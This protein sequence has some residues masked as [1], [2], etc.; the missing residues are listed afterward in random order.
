M[1][2]LTDQRHGPVQRPPPEVIEPGTADQGDGAVMT[3]VEHL[4]ELR[5]RI[6]I[7]ILAI[8]L[9][10][11]VGFILTPDAIRLLSAPIHQPLYFT[12]PGGAFFV[13]LKVALM[14]GIVLGSPVVLYEL[15]A[16]VSPGLTERE[17]RLARPW[18]PLAILFTVLGVGVAY[19]ILPLTTGFLLSFQIPGVV[20][21]LIT[22]DAYFG[23]VTTMFLAFGVVMQF[24]IVIVLLAKVGIVSVERLRRSRRYVLLGI[25]IFAV[26][27]T[28]GGDPFSPTIMALVMYPLYE[29]TIWMVG[30]SNRGAANG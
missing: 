10:T 13:E 9:G 3:L 7:G 12:A 23:F 11:V 14:I 6:F 24:P 22:A 4:G 28:P 2:E 29:F 15:W 8:T 27:I 18:I 20:E 30:R 25:F 19:L 26:V 17:R 21:P 5:R 16:F 1:A